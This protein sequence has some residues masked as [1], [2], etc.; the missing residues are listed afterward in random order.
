MSEEQEIKD[1]NAAIS[2]LDALVD[3]EFATLLKGHVE[4]RDLQSRAEKIKETLADKIVAK[5][6]EQGLDSVKA[7]G[8][9]AGFTT[10]KNYGIAAGATQ[11][12]RNANV[13]AVKA[14]LESVAP[15]LNIPAST[16]IANAVKIYLDRNPGAAMPAFIAVTETKSLTNAKG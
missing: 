5:M 6:N 15:D 7:G 3:E 11:E 9:R 13:A 10:R 14:W 8:R 16:N 12:E 1:V 2:A 4:A